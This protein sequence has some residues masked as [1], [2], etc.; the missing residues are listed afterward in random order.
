MS[1]QS[2]VAMLEEEMKKSRE[3]PD[4]NFGL[5]VGKHWPEF[6]TNLLESKEVQQEIVMSFMMT[7][8]GGISMKDKLDKV[9]PKSLS[10]EIGKSPLAYDS[11]LKFLFW[12]IEIGKR[13]AEVRQLEEMSK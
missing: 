6:V 9:N 3:F 11:P 4:K 2:V 8:L 10:G 7:M 13:I 12:G 5:K 1:N